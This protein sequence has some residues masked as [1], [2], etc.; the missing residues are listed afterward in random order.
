MRRCA[1]A[2]AC[3]A[4]LGATDARAQCQDAGT[5]LDG[6]CAPVF[7]VSVGLLPSITGAPLLQIDAIIQDDGSIVGPGGAVLVQVN[8]PDGGGG[9]LVLA[10]GGTVQHDGPLSTPLSF[11]SATA[12]A[13]VTT[14][15]W[16]GGTLLFLGENTVTVFAAQPTGHTA[17]STPQLVLLDLSF[18]AGS[19]DAGVT[20]DGGVAPDGGSSPDAGQPGSDG[21]VGSPDGGGGSPSTGGSSSTEG[22]STT[23]GPPSFF[24]MALGV[25]FAAL[26]RRAMHR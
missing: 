24:L 17:S 4:V 12:D 15:V 6:G 13:G 7:N 19:P 20:P 3:L 18:D 14:S 5:A 22:C 11:V 2:I 9:I 8:G 25:M 1:V 26:G 21:G 10:D 23:G 16:D